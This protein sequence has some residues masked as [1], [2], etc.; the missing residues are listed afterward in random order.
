MGYNPWGHKESDTTERLHFTSLHTV[1]SFSIVNEADVFL[2]FSR[3]FYDPMDV[4]NLT[5]GSSAF[6]KF[7][8]SV[9]EGE[10]G[11]IWENGIET[12]VTSCM[13]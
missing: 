10:G 12:C 3:F 2:E 9:G 5:S 13:K 7:S 4:S 11:K 1:K 6:S 8:Y